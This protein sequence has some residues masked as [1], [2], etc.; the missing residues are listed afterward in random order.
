MKVDVPITSNDAIPS[1]EAASGSRGSELKSWPTLSISD[2]I[3]YSASDGKKVPPSSEEKG[4]TLW[5]VAPR[6]AWSS[7]RLRWS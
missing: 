2:A 6:T 5:L 4:D 7:Y 1:S 3:T